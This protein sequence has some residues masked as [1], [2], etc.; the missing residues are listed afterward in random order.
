[1][2]SRFP[3]A[4]KVMPTCALLLLLHTAAAATTVKADGG[5]VE[6][7]VESGL[8]IYRGTTPSPPGT[9]STMTC[10]GCSVHGVT[11]RP[12]ADERSSR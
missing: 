8:Q 2:S 3:R 5:R 10:I 12:V 9:F 4:L 6:G 7:T 1:M 11:V